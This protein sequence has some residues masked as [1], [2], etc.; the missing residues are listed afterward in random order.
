MVLKQAC[1]SVGGSCRHGSFRLLPLGLLDG[2]EFRS[3]PSKF[4]YHMKTN[5]GLCVVAVLELWPKRHDSRENGTHSLGLKP[6]SVPPSSKSRQGRQSP[7][8]FGQILEGVGADQ[9][10]PLGGAPR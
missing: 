8:A 1:R 9:A 6:R 7:E 3:G 5:T 2:S 10:M 4:E